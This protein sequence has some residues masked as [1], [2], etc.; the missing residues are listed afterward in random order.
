MKTNRV[1]L[2]TIAFFSTATKFGAFG[3]ED[4]CLESAPLTVYESEMMSPQNM[5]FDME[6]NMFIA[7]DGW[8]NDVPVHYYKFRMYTPSTYP[9]LI[10]PGGSAADVPIQKVYMVTS[11]G[12]FD[13]VIGNRFWSITLRMVMYIPTLWKFNL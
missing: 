3:Q 10:A 4:A 5:D 9:G 6:N 8:Y 1:L 11:T 7:H 12:G 2:A 13:G